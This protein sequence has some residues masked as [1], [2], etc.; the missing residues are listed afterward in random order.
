MIITGRRFTIIG[1]ALFGATKWYPVLAQMTGFD[2]RQIWRC[3][4]GKA[5]VPPELRAK[6]S[7]ICR[8]RGQAL[9]RLADDIDA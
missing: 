4:I 7:A 5:K 3:A 8:A 6:L 9:L 1:E 2:R